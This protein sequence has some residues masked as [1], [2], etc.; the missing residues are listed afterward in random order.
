M[1]FVVHEH[2]ASRLHFDFRLE[3]AGVLKSWAV[4]KGPSL[5]PND[6]RLAVEVEDHSLSYGGFEGTIS[7]GRYGAGEVRIWDEGTYEPE[8]DAVARIREGKLTFRLSG[9]KLRG[10]FSLVR[11]DRGE[12]QWLLIKARD[13]FAEAGWELKTILEPRAA[14][15][16]GGKESAARKSAARKPAAE[17]RARE[18]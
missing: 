10:A 6:K 9:G 18:G 7:E 2:H 14:K 3:A 17:K 12:G 1:R 13:E 8:G 11:M 4:P 16:S 5:D 15:R